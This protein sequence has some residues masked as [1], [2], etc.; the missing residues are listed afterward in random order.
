MQLCDT[1][2]PSV[3]SQK[4]ALFYKNIIRN[5][6]LR[7][8]TLEDFFKFFF[9]IFF[10]NVPNEHGRPQKC[11]FIIERSYSQVPF[12]F[13]WSKVPVNN[14]LFAGTLVIKRC[15]LTSTSSKVPV[16]N[17]LFE[18]TVPPNNFIL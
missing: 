7:M 2:R 4:N 10:S 13:V 3:M 17:E 14:S 9:S 15:V 6:K 5:D 11:S 8:L 18:G 12:F 16:N 1:F